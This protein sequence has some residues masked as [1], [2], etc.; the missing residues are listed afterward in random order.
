MGRTTR[1][2]TA[3]RP[4]A[5]L[6]QPARH[7]VRS[8]RRA[9]ARR[10]AARCTAPPAPA[11]RK[12]PARGQVR[13]VPCARIAAAVCASRSAGL[14]RGPASARAALQGPRASGPA[15]A[16]RSRATREPVEGRSAFR[17]APTARPTPSAA[18]TSA[19][20]RRATSAPSTRWQ[21]AVRRQRTVRQAAETRA[22]PPV[23]TPAS[24][25]IR[26]PARV[27]SWGRCAPLPPTA[28]T[29]AASMTAPAARYAPLPCSRTV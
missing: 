10:T 5:T 24:A 1:F 2:S 27:A 19:T 11:H 25:A 15:T 17:K 18:P 14:P 8:A 13:R 4:L 21:S 28:A 7:A 26:D 12:A 16:A 22:A 3:R 29:G 23:T 20:P 9:G 6:R